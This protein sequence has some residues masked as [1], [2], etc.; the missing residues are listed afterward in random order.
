[1]IGFNTLDFFVR[2]YCGYMKNMKSRITGACANMSQQIVIFAQK[3][4]K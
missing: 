1:M 4:S 3:Q 2:I